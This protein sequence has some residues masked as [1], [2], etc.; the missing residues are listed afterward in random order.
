MEMRITGPRREVLHRGDLD[1]LDRH[2]NH[3]AAELH[4]HG[5]VLPQVPQ[6][7][8]FGV[9]LTSLQRRPHARIEYRENAPLLRPV[10]DEVDRRDMLRVHPLGPPGRARVRIQTLAH[11]PCTLAAWAWWTARFD[12]AGSES[13]GHGIGNGLG[14]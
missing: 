11:V 7:L 5:P 3:P 12:R 14:H 8:A 6:H 9:D 10:H 2:P 1:A 4:L 13:C